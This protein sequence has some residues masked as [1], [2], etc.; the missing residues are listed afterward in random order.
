M[1]IRDTN[2]WGSLLVVMTDMFG[3]ETHHWF[4][5]EGPRAIHC[6][7]VVYYGPDRYNMPKDQMTI[8]EEVRE[9]VR[10]EGYIIVENDDVEDLCQ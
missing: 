6:Q 9:A 5:L 7:K 10:D 2:T 4:D 1:E 3:T 8:P